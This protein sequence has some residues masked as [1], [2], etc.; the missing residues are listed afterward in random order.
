MNDPCLA[1]MQAEHLARWFMT[2]VGKP[3]LVIN[4][5]EDSDD[6]WR[7]YPSGFP[8]IGS[9]KTLADALDDACDYPGCPPLGK[10]I[11]GD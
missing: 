3:S 8:A 11:E 9:G 10:P 1:M 7:V 4:A 5:P 2:L 6:M